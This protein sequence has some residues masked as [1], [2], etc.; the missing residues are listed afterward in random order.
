MEGAAAAA[1][2]VAFDEQRPPS[3]KPPTQFPLH[4]PTVNP[5]RRR[6]GIIRGDDVLLLLLLVVACLAF[7][8][9]RGRGKKE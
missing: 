5:L 9:R 3:Q 2:M 4:I 6:S 8:M 1:A 7:P